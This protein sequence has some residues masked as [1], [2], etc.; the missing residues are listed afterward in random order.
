MWVDKQIE[1]CFNNLSH[2]L[3]FDSSYVHSENSPL[4]GLGVAFGSLRCLLIYVT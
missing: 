3:W 2:L 4:L 1:L